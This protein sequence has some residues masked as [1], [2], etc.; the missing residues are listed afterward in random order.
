MN[1][2]YRWY[3]RWSLATRQFLFLFI[4]TFAFF[5]L[6]A[7]NN[8]HKAADLFKDQMVSDSEILIARTNQF[9]DTYL[10]NSRN[11]L[12]LLSTDT[13]LLRE[14]DG[15]KLSDSLRYIAENNSTFVKTLYIIRKDGKVFSSSQVNYEII[16]NPHLSAIYDKSQQTYGA[17][18]VSQPYVSPLS[19]QTVAISRPVNDDNGAMIGV[20]VVELDIDKLNQKITELTSGTYQTFVIMSDKDKVV[21]FDR[22][23]VMLPQRPA[24]YHEDLP[25]SFVGQLADLPITASELGGQTG[26]LVVVK[27]GENRLGW[28]LLVLIKDRYFYQNVIRLFDNYKT[29]AA[30]WFVVLLFMAF[31]MSRYMTKSVRT[32]AAK[33]DRVHDMG[34]IPSLVVKREDEIGRLAQSFNAMMERIRNLLMETKQMEE[35]KKLLELKVLQSQIAPHFLYNTLACIG[36][37]AKQHRTEEVKETIRSLV[38]VLSLSFDKTSEYITVEEELEGLN[39]YMQIQK[40]RYGDKFTYVQEVDAEALSCDILKLTLQ[41]I[42]ENAVFHGVVPSR[43]GDGFIRVRGS[44]RKG[45]LRFFIRDNGVGMERSKLLKALQE[46]SP[47]RSDGQFTG[48]GMANV[49]HRLRLRY[50]DAYGLRIGSLPNAGTVVCITIPVEKR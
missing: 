23:S 12:L 22:D 36:S 11:V 26:K 30:I 31:A 1:R 40:I 48:I 29:A 43:G 34:V 9:L 7:W 8:Y 44:V 3:R 42:L 39:M 49:H 17:A 13:K 35:R 32:L 16:G 18:V 46:R 38:G 21:T 10:D 2:L 45:K 6:L 20:A 4:V 19:G 15:R 41:P 27:S 28:T 47:E 14:G 37:L 5:I 24:S 33:M 25:E 50:G